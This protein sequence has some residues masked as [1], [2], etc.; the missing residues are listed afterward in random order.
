MIQT[1]SV[2]VPGTTTYVEIRQGITDHLGGHVNKYAYE[3]ETGYM[4]P[5]GRNHT[6]TW[7]RH[8]IREA[9]AC[10]ADAINYAATH[11]VGR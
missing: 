10:F 8:N 7:G 6:G 3:I 4:A 5:W 2:I 11:H 9:S 1:T